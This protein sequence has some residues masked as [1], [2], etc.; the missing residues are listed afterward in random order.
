[1]EV[2]HA[3]LADNSARGTQAAVSIHDQPQV[4]ESGLEHLLR[5]DRFRRNC[6]RVLL[7][8]VG[9]HFADYGQL[10]LDE[11]DGI[12]G[13]TYTAGNVDDT[14]AT[15]HFENEHGW[16][17]AK[18]FKLA[19]SLDRFEVACDVELSSEAAVK[20]QVGIELVAQFSR[21]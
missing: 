21:S 2:Y 11:D 16:H 13:G 12:A 19:S 20:A 9:K 3:R 5:Y 17:I 1:M 4:K 6:F 10:R 8:S 7:F 18:S 15:L 14:G